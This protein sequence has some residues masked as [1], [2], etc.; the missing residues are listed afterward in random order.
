MDS[1]LGEVV[2]LLERQEMDSWLGEVVE[3]V[4]KESE[5]RK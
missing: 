5:E 1:W 4:K 2:K 3:E